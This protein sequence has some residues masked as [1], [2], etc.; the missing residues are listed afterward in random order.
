MKKKIIYLF[1][2]AG[3]LNLQA[4]GINE[5]IMCQADREFEKK[6][7]IELNKIRKVKK[8]QLNTDTVRNNSNLFVTQENIIKRQ[9]FY[10][11]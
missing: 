3:F 2:F 8:L 1:F 5:K 6:L 9:G 7:N 4:N 11:E 10:D